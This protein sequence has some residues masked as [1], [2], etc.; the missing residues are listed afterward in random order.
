MM[1]DNVLGNQNIVLGRQETFL[2]RFEQEVAKKNFQTPSSKNWRRGGQFEWKFFAGNFF[3]V[4]FF[5][6]IFQ[7]PLKS[8][9]VNVL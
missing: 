3:W 5:S 7:Y 9:V 4:L 1:F 6:L 2:W 8:L